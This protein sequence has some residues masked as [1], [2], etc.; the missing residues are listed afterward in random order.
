MPNINLDHLRAALQGLHRATK[1]GQGNPG[2]P[3]SRNE[4][5]N[6]LFLIIALRRMMEH[7]SGLRSKYTRHGQSLSPQR[8]GASVSVPVAAKGAPPP[9]FREWVALVTGEKKEEG[10]G[11]WVLLKIPRGE[12]GFGISNAGTEP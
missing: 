9:D 2:L 11:R 3:R 4:A 6:V 5:K 1:L 10:G 8:P 12:R 7:E